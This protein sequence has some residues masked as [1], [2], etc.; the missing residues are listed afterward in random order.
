[1][2]EP[3]GGLFADAHPC[4]LQYHAIPA[5]LV[6]VVPL[7]E[8]DSGV[9]SG[10]LLARSLFVCNRSSLLC[11]AMGRCAAQFPACSCACALHSVALGE[12]R[13]RGQST[14]ADQLSSACSSLF[15]HARGGDAAVWQPGAAT[16][17]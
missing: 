7:E 12:Q 13:V 14:Q 9:A 2:R 5:G 10:S 8:R 6:A 11:C 3:C 1:M 16:A 17:S 4:V 15:A